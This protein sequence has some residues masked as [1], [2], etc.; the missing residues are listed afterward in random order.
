MQQLL[1]V[2]RCTG[3]GTVS[4]A[5]AHGVDRHVVSVSC[6]DVACR[7]AAAVVTLWF[8]FL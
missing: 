2:Y 3:V 1:L 8:D 4:P 5:L 6:R 7:R